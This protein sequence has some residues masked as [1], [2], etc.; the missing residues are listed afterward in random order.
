MLIWLI[1]PFLNH[2]YLESYHAT[3]CFKYGTRITYTL[4]FTWKHDLGNYVLSWSPWRKATNLS[5]SMLFEGRHCEFSYKCWRFNLRA[6]SYWFHSWWFTRDYDMFVMQMYGNLEPIK[7]FDVEALLYVQEVQLDK[8]RH[9]LVVS[10]DVDCTNQEKVVCMKF[11]GVIKAEDA[12]LVVDVMVKVSPRH[13]IDLLVN[14]V[15][16]KVM[17]FLIIHTYLMKS[18]HLHEPNPTW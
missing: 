18:S 11:L 17:L 15:G 14:Y 8:F 12:W 10:S 5:L 9:E 7:P 3:M 6:R 4:M 1:F 13:V 16:I 2:C